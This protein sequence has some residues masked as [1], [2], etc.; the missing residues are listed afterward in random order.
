MVLGKVYKLTHPDCD[1]IYIGSTYCHYS[2]VRMAHHRQAH[3]RGEKDYQ[4]LFDNG[5][6]KMEILETIELENPREE[7]WKLRQLEESHSQQ[8]ENTLNER[9]CYLTEEEKI[10]QRNNSINK[11]HKSPLGKL[12][13]RKS[14]LNQKVNS[15]SFGETKKLEFLRLII[16]NKKIWILDEPLSNLDNESIDVIAQTFEDHRSKEG[17]IIFSSHQ[18]S[19][20]NVSEEVL[21]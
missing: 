17:S 13:L 12:A 15:L 18:E 2:S 16:E 7:A 4:G 14:Y 5:D 1:K 10:K 19:E 8:Y 11:Y 21:L 20:I 9:R 6:P 3:R